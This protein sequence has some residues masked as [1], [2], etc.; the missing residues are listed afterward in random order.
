MAANANNPGPAGFWDTGVAEHPWYY[1]DLACDLA[2]QTAIRDYTVVEGGTNQP[3]N[4]IYPAASCK[5]VVPPTTSAWQY[6]SVAGQQGGWL[7]GTPG[8]TNP[9]QKFR[10]DCVPG[11][12]PQATSKETN[13][14]TI[15]AALGPTNSTGSRYGCNLDNTSL[16]SF[17]W[18]IPSKRAGGGWPSVIPRPVSYHV[19]P[20]PLTGSHK[21]TCG[22]EG[23]TT[24]PGG[25]PHLLSFRTMAQPSRA[26]WSASAS[27]GSGASN[28]IDNNPDSWWE[29]ATRGATGMWF[30]VDMGASRVV[31]QVTFDSGGDTL[32]YPNGYQVQVSSNGT[33][34]TT[35]ATGTGTGP[36]VSAR[37]SEQFVRYVQIKLTN[38]FPDSRPNW[39]TIRELNV[40]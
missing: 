6:R 35:M 17:Y 39:W 28:A 22:M 12:V 38:N 33:T 10:Y 20:V 24:A 23:T 26:G 4:R 7:M 16:T 2:Q 1:M 27:V 14:V 34:W 30:K 36:F 13:N 37:F 19:M 9:T 32:D 3:G 8:G 31:Q 40:Y 5:V 15:E 29:S 18:S 21:V 11:S 25:D